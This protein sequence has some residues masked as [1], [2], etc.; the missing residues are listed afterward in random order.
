MTR[1]QDILSR[2]LDHVDDDLIAAAHAPHRKWRR[3]RPF[4]IAACV[5]VVVIAVF[6]LLRDLIDTGYGSL[7]PSGDGHL[8][9][10][11]EAAIPLDMPKAGP[12]TPLTLGGTTVTMTA[13]SNTTA[14]FTVQKTDDAPL[15]IALFGLRGNTMAST[16]PDYKENGITI[17]PYTIRLTVNGA[18]AHTYNLPSAPGTYTVV[19]DFASVRNGTYPMRELMGFYNYGGKDDARQSIAFL[20]DAEAGTDTEMTSAPASAPATEPTTTPDT[21]PTA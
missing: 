4:L 3:V 20:L 18:S 21:I 10:D 5:L 17:R 2:A 13:V 7:G 15:Y 1:E 11:P 8:S 14:T 16:E 9:D 12:D 6:P 19:V